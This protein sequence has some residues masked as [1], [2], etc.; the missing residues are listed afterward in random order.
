MMLHRCSGGSEADVKSA[1]AGVGREGF[2]CILKEAK[3]V[4]VPGQVAGSLGGYGENTGC[5]GLLT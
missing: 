2:I 1:S 5:T 4:Q 3:R